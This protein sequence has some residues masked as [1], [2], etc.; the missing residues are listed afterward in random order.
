MEEYLK[1]LPPEFSNF[2]RSIIKKSI[3]RNIETLYKLLNETTLYDKR[4]FEKSDIVNW[5]INSHEGKFKEAK[6]FI[7]N[8]DYK[9]FL[10]ESYE[11]NSEILEDQKREIEFNMSYLRQNWSCWKDRLDVKNGIINKFDID[12]DGFLSTSRGSLCC[13]FIPVKNGI[14]GEIND[15]IELF[16]PRNNKIEIFTI[17]KINEEDNSYRCINSKNEIKYL[18]DHQNV[19]DAYSALFPINKEIYSGWW[20][21]ILIN[22]YKK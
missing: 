7:P 14:N 16:N 12:S 4:V 19:K 13:N 3:L 10:K 9:Y 5:V 15:K 2:K 22:N 18:I 17:L 6:N 21:K 8:V 20:N 1:L 11:N